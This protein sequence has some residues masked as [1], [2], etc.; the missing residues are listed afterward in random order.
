[1]LR[2]MATS[3]RESPRVLPPYERIEGIHV[4]RL[5]GNDYEMGLQHGRLLKEAIARGPIPYFARWVEKLME[6]GFFGPLAP[7]SRALGHALTYTV[8]RRIG[9]K[10][11]KHVQDAIRGLADGAEIDREELM[12]AVTMPETYL[13]L[14]VWYKRLFK[15]PIA[16]RLG[17]PVIG[18]TSAIAWGDATTHHRLLHGRNF[19][20]QGVG[21]W[22]KEQAAIFHEPDDGQPYI[23]VAAAGVLL[24]GATAMNASGIS[25]VVHQHIASVDFDLDGLPVGVVGDLV[26][27]HAKNLD[28]AT[29][30]LDEHRP[31]GAWTYIVASAKERRA[32]AYEVSAHHR[33]IVHP[34][35]D[36]FGYSNIFL[37][38]TIEKTEVDFYPAYWRNNAARYLAA[39]RRLQSARGRID[40]DEIASIL[41]D[42]GDRCRLSDNIS[43]LTTVASVVFD[44][45]RALVYVAT[46]R[47]PVCNRPYLAFDLSQ[48]IARPDLPRLLGGARVDRKSLD[49]FDA[50]REAYERHFNDGDLEAARR[51]VE[52]ARDLAPDQSVYAFVAGLLALEASDWEG[53]LAAFDRAIEIGHEIPQRMA[54]FRLWRGRA[55]DALGR[56]DPALRDYRE[57][58]AGDPSVRRAARKNLSRAWKKKSPT[59]EWSYGEVLA[60]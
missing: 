41:G 57:A 14:G 45:E 7:F 33:A 11:P 46:G 35:D 19:D 47:P 18:C 28:D 17:V 59:I 49:A 1:M 3:L 4:L 13:W 25:L 51:L 8:G 58:L 36:T 26:M 5:K 32:I 52:R 12:R 50:Y 55:N 29:R 44:A 38:H 24:G 48:K 60:P 30:I 16:P 54:G 21:A 22:D 40:G 10:F 42:C 43:A 53:A 9:K 2:E 34:K 56:R 31:N 39:N 23:S 27:R 20:Y 15:T 6:R 37:D